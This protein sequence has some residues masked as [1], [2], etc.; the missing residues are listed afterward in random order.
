M[1]SSLVYVCRSDRAT[2]VP[3]SLLARV[4]S[5]KRESM[6]RMERNYGD[7]VFI[8]MFTMGKGTVMREVVTGLCERRRGGMRED[9]IRVAGPPDVGTPTPP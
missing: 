1:P 9:M 5:A 6:E 2:K 3:T 8:C 4:N 7:R